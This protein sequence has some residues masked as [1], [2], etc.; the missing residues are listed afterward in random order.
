MHG[1]E[2]DPD[3]SPI[4]PGIVDVLE[5]PSRI[6]RPCIRKSWLEKGPGADTDKRGAEPFYCVNF[7]SDGRQH[8]ARPDKGGVRSAGPEEASEWVDYCNNPSDAWPI[9]IENKINMLWFNDDDGDYV[10]CTV[11]ESSD[12]KFLSDSDNPLRAAMIC[13]LKM[14]EKQQ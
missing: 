3:P 10:S 13:F 9:I 11:G 2:L 8:W 1:F 4:G 6:T 12:N 7:E 5:G 14:K